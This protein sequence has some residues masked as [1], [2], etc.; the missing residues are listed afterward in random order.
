MTTD[1]DP[2][3]SQ[4]RVLHPDQ[5]RVFSERECAR[6]QGFPDTYK[7]LWHGTA[8]RYKQVG[9]A[10]PP[11]LARLLGLQILEAM[12]MG[13]SGESQLVGRRR[14]SL[15]DHG[16]SNLGNKKVRRNLV[17]DLTDLTDT[18]DEE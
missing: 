1:Q 18:E 9:N 3:K 4:G 8:N 6:A 13:T 15:E 10:V 7:F 11:P 12:M 17:I 14:K 2:N 5:P 16:S